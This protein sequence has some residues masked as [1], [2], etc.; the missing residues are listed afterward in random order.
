LEGKGIV[1]KVVGRKINI[2]AHLLFGLGAI[3]ISLKNNLG[4][5]GFLIGT[6]FI[7]LA[8]YEFFK[9]S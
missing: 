2:A 7:F 5:F 3:L 4:P 1:K 9:K 8:I 6:L